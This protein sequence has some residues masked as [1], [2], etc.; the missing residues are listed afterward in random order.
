[1]VD[2]QKDLRDDCQLRLEWR[3]LAEALS[4]SWCAGQREASE[5]PVAKASL[6]G[7]G[8]RFCASSI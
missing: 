4:A 3:K 7:L 6:S 8:S 5:A 2:T 1:M